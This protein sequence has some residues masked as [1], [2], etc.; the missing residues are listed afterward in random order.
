MKIQFKNTPEQIELVKAMGSKDASVSREAMEIFAAF[1]GP[2]IQQVINTTGT[3]SLI[4]ADKPYNEDDSPSIPLDLFYDESVNYISTWSQSIAGGLP[5]NQIE[6]V[7]EMKVST[8]RLDS[9]ISFMKKYA[10]RSRLDVVAKAT[11]RMA[12][13]ILIKQERNAWAVI[14]KAL[15]EA[16]TQTLQHVLKSA[17]ADVFLIPDLSELITRLRRIN[18][19]FN[20][21]TPS[22]G[23]S[24]GLTDLFVSPEIKEQIRNFAFN[25]MN[26]RVGPTVPGS[27]LTNYTATTAIPLP[28]AIRSEIF[29]SA[30]TSEI[31][32][33][34]ITDLLELG[35][36]KKYNVLF[37]EFAGGTS[38][39]GGTFSS[40]NDE[41]LVGFDLSREA[42]IRP[43]AQ[44][45]DSGATFN[46]QPDDQWVSRSE[47]IG[48]YGALE[49]GRVCIDAR[50]VCGIIV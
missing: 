9:A 2:V 15:A 31:Y 16:T 48:W 1:I 19:A 47:K 8:Y 29:R 22:G 21:G 41:L 5:T 20:G 6:G 40:A 32:G 30:G 25:P 33:V 17:T 38:Y 44:N 24:E 37:S 28:D 50:G 36:S 27:T 42:F 10:R 14:L 23:D 39:D 43:I 7:K 4:Y 18:A 34:N 12:Q 45:A 35:T 11:E 46:T 26:T 13:E 3:A 49:E